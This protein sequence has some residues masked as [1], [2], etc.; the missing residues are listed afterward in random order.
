M[1]ATASINIVAELLGLGK[2]SSFLDR[3]TLAETPA[4]KQQNYKQISSA[5]TE[6]ALDLG[7]VATVDLIIIKAIGFDLTVDTSFNS[8]YSPEITVPAGQVAVFN[9][10][11]TVYIK[12]ANAGEDVVYEYF[13]IGR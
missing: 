1:A 11:G 12:N 4:A 6:E 2:D 3:F 9:P 8:T 10:V 13:V 7:G 5:D